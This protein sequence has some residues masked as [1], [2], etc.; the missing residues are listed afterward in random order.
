MNFLLTLCQTV[1][2]GKAD[3]IVTKFSTFP[4]HASIAIK[5]F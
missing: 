3:P 2:W 1:S 5:I 4:L